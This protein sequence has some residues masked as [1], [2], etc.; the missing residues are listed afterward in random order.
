MDFYID[1]GGPGSHLGG[2][3][4]DPGAE[5]HQKNENFQNFEK[6]IIFRRATIT[7]IIITTAALKKNEFYLYIGRLRHGPNSIMPI[8]MALPPLRLYRCCC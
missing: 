4:T 3:R 2:S 7:T 6:I 5:K 1:P 8:I